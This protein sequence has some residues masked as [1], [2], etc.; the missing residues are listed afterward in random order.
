MTICLLRFHMH[1]QIYVSAH[2]IYWH[3]LSLNWNVK[4]MYLISFNIFLLLLFICLY[5]NRVCF[6]QCM[7][8]HTL[9]RKKNYFATIYCFLQ[10]TIYLFYSG[11]N[12]TSTPYCVCIYAYMCGNIY[13]TWANKNFNLRF[14]LFPFLN[15]EISLIWD[16]G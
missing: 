16:I 9:N 7:R 4:Y 8:E 15:G 3:T 14:S 13:K 5:F 2:F 6:I 10:F 1:T 12:I 11:R